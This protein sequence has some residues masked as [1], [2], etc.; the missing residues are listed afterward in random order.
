MIG[1]R[2][3]PEV[4]HFLWRIGNLEQFGCGFVHT[5]VRRLRRQRHGD[6]QRIGVHMVQLTLGFGIALAE[7]R[8]N[9]AD[10]GVVQLFGQ[11]S[12]GALVPFEC[13]SRKGWNA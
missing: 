9:L 2:I 3:N 7:P 11:L 6:D 12:H 1:Q 8:E 10:R 5:L 4:E 13:A